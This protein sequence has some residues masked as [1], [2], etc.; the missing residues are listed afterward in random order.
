MLQDTASILSHKTQVGLASE[1]V[2][3]PVWVEW[4][5]TNDE[6]KPNLLLILTQ[7]ILRKFTKCEWPLWNHYSQESSFCLRFFPPWQFKVM[8]HLT[9]LLVFTIFW[10]LISLVIELT[11]S[12]EE[13]LTIRETWI[14]T[15]IYKWQ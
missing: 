14:I 11:L 10:L 12:W 4:L 7:S 5:N 6:R 2:F 15:K 13:K 1:I 8:P 3:Q 9:I